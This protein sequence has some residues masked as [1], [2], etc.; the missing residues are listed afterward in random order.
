MRRHRDACIAL[1]GLTIACAATARDQGFDVFLQQHALEGTRLQWQIDRLRN[2]NP[3]ARVQAA[4][5][6]AAD[7]AM[8]ASTS[9]LLATERQ[10][11]L[12]DIVAQLPAGDRAAARPRLEM[13]RQQLA[14]GAVLVESMRG[15]ERDAIA[16]KTAMEA[17]SQAGELLRPLLTSDSSRMDRQDPLASVHEGADLLDAWRRTLQAWVALHGG[18]A[19]SDA[20]AAKLEL[21]RAIVLFARLVDADAQSPAPANASADLLRTEMGADAALGLAAALHAAGRDAAGDAWLQA[22]AGEA[23]AT[24][25]AGRVALWRLAFAIDRQDLHAMRE[26]LDHM[27]PRTLTPG[28][29]RS[30][31]RAALQSAEAQLP[32][33]QR[34]EG[35]PAD[36]AA[37]AAAL[38][39]GLAKAGDAAPAP[40]RAEALRALGYALVASGDAAA[41]SVAF[42]QAAAVRPSL[43]P[44]CLWLAAVH[45]PAKDAAAQRRRIDLLL[46]QRESDPLGPYAGRVATWLSQ[47]DGFPSDAVATAVLLEVPDRDALFAAARAEAARRILRGGAEDAAAQT[48]SA[49]RALRVTDACVASPLVAR[50]RLLAATTP[51]AQDRLSAEQALQALAATERLDAATLLAI[52]RLQVMQGDMSALQATLAQAPAALRARLAL[53]AAF[54][55]SDMQAADRLQA[56]VACARL[57]ADEAGEDAALAAAAR[58]RLARS[59]LA[60]A[61]AEV[62]IDADMCAR[63]IETLQRTPSASITEAFALAESLRMAGRGAEAAERMQVLSGTLAQGTEPWLEA[64]WRLY[65]A[66]QSFD[67]TRAASM[68]QQH[69]TLLPEGGAQPWGALFRD[70]AQTAPRTGA[71]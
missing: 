15:T 19:S 61:D 40:M 21:E 54:A 8:L 53:A 55:L 48:R 56:A 18:G 31:A 39:D 51:G 5:E 44:E 3:A 37:V 22:V 45:E 4:R 28:L 1:L 23:S 69:M 43:R 33:W 41:A 46:R 71:P 64:R 38:R 2:G 20:A 66:L 14:E 35:A 60:A 7:P 52:V 68:L 27:P 12:R 9:A 47:L 50:W 67:A 6:I 62:A 13:A 30:A 63:V 70:A 17:L 25:A 34:R 59:V 11:V 24:T 32:A 16:A 10:A 65:R 42:E 29:A 58:D 57:A 36:A 49:E 26:V